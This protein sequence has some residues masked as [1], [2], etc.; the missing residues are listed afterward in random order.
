MLLL[1][2]A[3]VFAGMFLPQTEVSAAGI[4][5]KKNSGSQCTASEHNYQAKTYEAT[6]QDYKKTVYTC[7]ICNDS[8]T[9]YAG[10]TGWSTTKPENVKTGIIE[11]RTEYRYR[12]KLYTSSTSS[13]LDGWTMYDYADRWT[14]YGAWSSWS[15]KSVTANDS[16]KVEK[17][18][19]YGY[20]YFLCPYCGVHMH[21]YGSCYTWA[22]GCGKATTESGWREV[23]S[24]VSWNNANLKDWHGTGKYYTYLNGELVFK[25][26]SGGSK[27]QYRYCTRSQERIYYF[28]C[29]ENWSGW[30]PTAVS[31]TSDKEVQTRTVYRYLDAE[32]GAHT[33]SGATDTS[34]DVCGET[35]IVSLSAPTIAASNDEATGKPKISWSKVTG[36]DKYELYR[37][38]SKSGTYTKIGSTTG[39]SIINKSAV[40]GKQYYYKVKAVSNE[41]VVSSYSNIVNR[42]C[43]LPRPVV[44]ATN[45]ASTGKVKLSWKAIDGATGYEVYWA[46]SKD[47]SYTKIATVTGTSVT[48]SSAKA[49]KTYYYKVK[50]IHSNSAATSAYSAVVNRTCDLPQPVVTASNVASTGK[51]KL[52]WKAIDGATGYELYWAASKDGS[53]TK[54]ATVTGTSVTN[55]SAKAG[56]TYYYKVKAIHSNSAANSAYSEIVNRTCDLPQPTVT[57]TNVSSTGKVKL[58]WTAIDGATGYELYWAASKDGSYTKIATVTGTSVTNSSAKAG[59]TY[60]Y[61][62]RA[63]HSNTAANS[64]YSAIVERTCDLAQPTVTATNVASSGKVKL[65]W[66][67]VDGATKYEVYRATSKSGTYSKLTTVTGTSVTNSSAVAGKSYYYKVRALFDNSA[68]TSVYSAIVNRTCDLAQPVLTVGLSDKGIPTLSWDAVSGATKYEVYRSTSK[69]GT[70]QLIDTVEATFKLDV[71]TT[72]GK[73]YYYK[74]RALCGNSAASSAYSQIK[75]ITTK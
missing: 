38:T 64:A 73:T 70:Y 45:V 34:C 18:T 15:D 69:N 29:W 48:N 68:A 50:A 8:Y 3:L 2:S 36:A 11:S 71:D 58:S 51:V 37:A 23:W 66:K 26:T 33:Y 49:G 7:T 4:L 63:T 13:T 17:R 40:T 25:W 22:G 42:T 67:A 12:N 10:M 14:D 54:I 72:A 75:Y 46:A 59:K 9:E 28:Y 20:Y 43:D 74:V 39:T 62:V 32:L 5:S 53:Y 57:A 27:T 24:T 52:S 21:G 1:V 19:V 16:T 6:C 41:G 35:R 47:G 55:S 31:A 44:T 61:K 30:S 65:S 56:K 60:Y